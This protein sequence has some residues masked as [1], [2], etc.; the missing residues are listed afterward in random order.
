MVLNPTTMGVENRQDFN[1]FFIQNF[2]CEEISFLEIENKIN[3]CCS[4]CGLEMLKKFQI[5]EDDFIHQNT[6]YPESKY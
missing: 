3:D 5:I 6:D 1:H 2:F 4:Y